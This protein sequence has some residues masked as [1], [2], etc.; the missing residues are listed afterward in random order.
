MVKQDL[1]VL[2]KIQNNEYDD[3]VDEFI[4]NSLDWYKK[5]AEEL[6]KEE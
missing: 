4:K 1:K 2:R 5:H 6:L 3:E